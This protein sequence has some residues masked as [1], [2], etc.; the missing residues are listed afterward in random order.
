MAYDPIYHNVQCPCQVTVEIFIHSLH[1][2]DLHLLSQ[3]H[4]IECS[5]EEGIEEAAME[6]GQTNDTSNEFEVI[7]VTRVDAGVGV[8]L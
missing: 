4:F 5:N 2:L 3:H 6:D 7:Q 8:D 1:I